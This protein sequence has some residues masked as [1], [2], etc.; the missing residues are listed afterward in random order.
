MQ[1]KELLKGKVY[2]TRS[3]VVR[4]LDTKESPVPAEV[5][6][7]ISQSFIPAVP[8]APRDIYESL[9]GFDVV[10][11]AACLANAHAL[12]QLFAQVDLFNEEFGA[13]AKAGVE[14]KQTGTKVPSPRGVTV[15]LST[16]DYNL[17]IEAGV[18]PP[19]GDVLIKG[20]D[21]IAFTER[22]GLPLVDVAPVSL[23]HPVFSADDLDPAN[24]AR[25]VRERAEKAERGQRARD[26]VNEVS[27]TLQEKLKE[28]TGR[29]YVS[30]VE[31]RKDPRFLSQVEAALADAGLNVADYGRLL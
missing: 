28:E 22:I 27:D 4:V 20:H 30:S 25:V 6:D 10:E 24:I 13:H 31:A 29:S 15:T 3:A 16:L 19:E 8:I 1:R 17:A 18:E 23:D 9:R 14:R 26:I 7:Y 5:F 21:F 12:R 11:V 2:S